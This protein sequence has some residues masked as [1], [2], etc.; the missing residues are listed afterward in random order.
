[1]AKF[2]VLK[3]RQLKYPDGSVR[4]E[5]GY[6]VDGDQA[7]ERATL[8]EQGDKLQRTERMAP[9]D[10]VDPARLMRAKVETKAGFNDLTTTPSK[11]KATKKKAKR[12]GILF[13]KK[14]RPDEV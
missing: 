12:K 14:E 7:Y 4:G 5:R 13:G 6:V 9:V 11:K 2:K 8:A 10:P 3:N 1:M